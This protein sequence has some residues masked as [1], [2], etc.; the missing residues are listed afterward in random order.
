MRCTA[1]AEAL[2]ERGHEI[3]FTTPQNERAPIPDVIV[4][5]SYDVL[6]PQIVA[7]SHI[8]AVVVIDDLADRDLRGAFAVINQN[9]GADALPYNAGGAQMLLGPAY[10]ML[11]R[12]FLQAQRR[13]HRE[14]TASDAR[15]LLTLGGGP[16]ADRLLQALS[17]LEQI[18]RALQITVMGMDEPAGFSTHHQ[19]NFVCRTDEPASL[20]ERA[21][22]C[23]TGGGVS[24]LEL[25]ALGTP[26]VILTLAAN[27]EPAARTLRRTGMA[28]VAGRFE[29]ALPG[30]SAVV[31]GLLSDTGRRRAL[32]SA[33]ME[34]V[35]GA[36]AQ[37]VA[38]F[39]ETIEVR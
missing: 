6:A 14:F 23:V 5:D 35:D 18:E 2:T 39:L 32:S 37:R 25:A 38:S 21:D 11:R 26:S 31:A 29:E 30:L 9:F 24:T 1:L 34:S 33:S 27:Q 36:G 4:V 16:M 15:V 17:A 7:W 20:M 22:L 8:A 3:F 19:T 10:A 12:Q 28:V 13:A